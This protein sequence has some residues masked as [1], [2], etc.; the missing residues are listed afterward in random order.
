MSKNRP[1]KK[2]K[3]KKKQEKLKPQRVKIVCP[4]WPPKYISKSNMSPEW[5][6]MSLWDVLKDWTSLFYLQNI[7]SAF[8]KAFVENFHR[9]LRNMTVQLN[10]L[11]DSGI[12]NILKY[13]HILNATYKE[14]RWDLRWIF[15][16]NEI[17]P[18]KTQLSTSFIVT[19]TSSTK[20]LHSGA[21]REK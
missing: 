11:L 5:K 6:R 15:Q 1:E 12:M 10:F 21:K 13:F 2:Q 14:P 18:V 4:F 3:N 19:I 20:V 9:F 8:W 7:R 17:E 16:L